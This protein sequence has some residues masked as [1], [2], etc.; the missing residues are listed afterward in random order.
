MT[1]RLADRKLKT[2]PSPKLSMPRVKR[3]GCD[4]QHVVTIHKDT[5]KASPKRT[6]V[7]TGHSQIKAEIRKTKNRKG[8]DRSHQLTIPLVNIRNA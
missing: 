8:Q 6:S 1:I 4:I 2:T 7:I 5:F 3:R